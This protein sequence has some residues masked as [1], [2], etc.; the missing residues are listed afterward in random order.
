MWGIISSKK[1]ETSKNIY[2]FLVHKRTELLILKSMY[3]VHSKRYIGGKY[4]DI[5]FDQVDS[6]TKGE[7][8]KNCAANH[9]WRFSMECM[10]FECLTFNCRQWKNECFIRSR[11]N[12]FWHFWW[13]IEYLNCIQNVFMVHEQSWW[14]SSLCIDVYQMRLKW[15]DYVHFFYLVAQLGFELFFMLQINWF[16][17]FTHFFSLS[18]CW[19]CTNYYKVRG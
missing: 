15:N 4:E 11:F 9:S 5:A 17:A 13:L 7:E 16:I 19:P 1:A 6:R 12:G 3:F 10:R 8:E 2:P 14:S 18:L